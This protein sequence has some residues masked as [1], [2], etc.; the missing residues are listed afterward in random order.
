M[1]TGAPV[2]PHHSLFCGAQPASPDLLLLVDGLRAL[3]KHS[4][5]G[6]V[7]AMRSSLHLFL[8]SVLG[9]SSL[10]LLLLSGWDGSQLAC[11]LLF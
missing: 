4:P 1:G 11:V 9:A 8:G 5:A 3:C 2:P 10:F 6:Y 7:D